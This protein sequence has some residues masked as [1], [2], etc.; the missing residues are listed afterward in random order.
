MCIVVKVQAIQ[1]RSVVTNCWVVAHFDNLPEAV[2]R[3]AVIA[4]TFCHLL[5]DRG[6]ARRPLVRPYRIRYNGR[7][8]SRRRGACQGLS[9][10]YSSETAEGLVLCPNNTDLSNVILYSQRT[11]FAH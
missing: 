7:L 3:V 6:T 10:D 2:P 11:V 5:V 1:G 9:V 8:T 4:L